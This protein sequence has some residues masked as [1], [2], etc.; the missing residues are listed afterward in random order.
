VH[1]H[2]YCCHDVALLSVIFWLPSFDHDGIKGVDLE[3]QVTLRPA[4]RFVQDHFS[5]SRFLLLPGVKLHFAEIFGRKHNG[6]E[7]SREKDKK[8]NVNKDV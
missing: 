2:H 4:A 7:A 1:K 5:P 8:K 3:I 6:N